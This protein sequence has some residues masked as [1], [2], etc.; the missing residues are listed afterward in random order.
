MNLSRSWAFSSL[1]VL[2]AAWRSA[3]TPSCLRSIFSCASTTD[4]VRSFESADIAVKKTEVVLASSSKVVRVVEEKRDE[5]RESGVASAAASSSADLFCA[6]ASAERDVSI[7]ISLLE[8]SFCD[9]A[10]LNFSLSVG[11]FFA[12]LSAAAFS[13]AAFWA[14]A[15]VEDHSI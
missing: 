7:W 10:S 6:T 11:A 2:S 15:L 1:A 14:A 13:A 4:F 3:M 5:S 8:A 9:V 12:F